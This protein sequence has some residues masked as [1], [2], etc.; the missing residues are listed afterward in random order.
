MTP[1]CKAKLFSAFLSVGRKTILT[2]YLRS[3]FSEGLRLSFKEIPKYP[4]AMT[5][6]RNVWN[7]D[8]DITAG[9]LFQF[10]VCYC[11]HDAESKFI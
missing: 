11:N 9:P 8:Y 5:L 6:V 1:A 7:A 3:Q 10:Y 4:N 2:F